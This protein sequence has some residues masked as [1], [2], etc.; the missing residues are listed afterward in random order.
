MTS[1]PDHYAEASRLL[2]A[3]PH[4]K[5]ERSDCKHERAM[6]RRAQVHAVLALAAANV[7]RDHG[8]LWARVTS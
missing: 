5:C 2:T 8:E 1:G 4:C 7:D 6:L 3:D